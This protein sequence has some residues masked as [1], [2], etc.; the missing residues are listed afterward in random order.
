M[1]LD[2]GI[3]RDLENRI[4]LNMH[5]APDNINGATMDSKNGKMSHRA[6]DASGL[7]TGVALAA[8]RRSRSTGERVQTAMAWRQSCR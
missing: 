3:V 1:K 2:M 6:R 8:G 5:H 4:M 7:D